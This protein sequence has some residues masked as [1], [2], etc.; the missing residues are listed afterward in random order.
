[1][2]APASD[3]YPDAGLVSTVFAALTDLH[4]EGAANFT[5]RGPLLVVA[6]HF[7]FA[8]PALMIRVAPSPVEMIG[9]HVMPNAPEQIC[10]SPVHMV[11][12]RSIV[13]PAGVRR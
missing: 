10:G 4:I 2:A 11:S 13:A 6:N 8:D 5:R 3:S 1:M 9:G 7:N 12:W